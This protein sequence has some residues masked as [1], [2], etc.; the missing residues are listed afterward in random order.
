[1]EA[2]QAGKAGNLEQAHP[3]VEAIEA[4]FSEVTMRLKSFGESS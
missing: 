2:E 3:I 1:M 4:E